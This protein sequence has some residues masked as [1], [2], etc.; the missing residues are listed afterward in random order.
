MRSGVDTFQ[1]TPSLQD[2][3]TQSARNIEPGMR[4][5]VLKRLSERLY[6]TY[7][8]SLTTSTR[9]QVVLL[10]FDSKRSSLV[11]P[12]AQ[13]RWHL[14]PR[15]AHQ[16]DVL[17]D[18]PL[19]WLVWVSG[20]MPFRS[21]PVSPNGQ[22]GQPIVEIQLDQEGRAVNE[23]AVLRLIETRVGIVW[24][25]RSVRETIAHLMALGPLRGRAGGE[26]AGRQWRPREVRA[27]AASS[28]RPH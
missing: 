7:S 21:V 10:E 22:V 8:R 17:D 5:T 6:L 26:R 18:A 27:D 19:P 16:E 1:I 25:V 11:D 2:P 20:V 28:D 23:P 14:R 4:L 3:N 15:L 9:D 13:R 24:R 12:V